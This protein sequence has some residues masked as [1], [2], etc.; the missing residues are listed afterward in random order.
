MDIPEQ[1]K[2]PSQRRK[3]RRREIT[4]EEPRLRKM[5][6]QERRAGEAAFGRLLAAMLADEEFVKAEAERQ[7]NATRD[8]GA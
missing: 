4:I 2:P 5:S 6:E 3:Y 8:H 7:R 1:Q